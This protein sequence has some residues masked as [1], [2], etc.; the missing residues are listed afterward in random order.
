MRPP[1]WPESK[2]DLVQGPSVALER[3]GTDQNLPAEH[4]VIAR[5]LYLS[6]ALPTS[7]CVCTCQAFPVPTSPPQMP[8]QAPSPSQLPL[9]HYLSVQ[10]TLCL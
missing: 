6:P 7:N 3:A 8:P 4:G 5:R 9:T 10:E 1:P 2:A